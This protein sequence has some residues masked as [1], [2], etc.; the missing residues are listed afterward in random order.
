[1]QH[2]QQ[3]FLEALKAAL[4][5]EQIEWNNKV[6]AQEWMDLFR[7]AEVHQ[8]LP[9]IYEAVYRSPAAGQ[10]DPQILAP[11]KAQMV[12]T[13]IMQTQKTGEFEPLYRYL[14]ESGI[15]P[16]VVKG[17]VCRNIYPNP[18]YRISGD[19]DLLIRP[20]DF[21]KCHDLLREYGM[22]TSEQ[23]MDAEE[24]ESVYEVPY[25]KKGSLIYI[26]LHKSL[27]PPESEA[28]GDLNR[29]FANVHEDAIDIRIDG[30]DIRTMG[31][32]DHLFYLICHSFKHFLH[33]GFGIR[34]VCDIILFANEYGDAIDWEKIL[35]QCREI[36]ADLFAAALFAIGEKYLTF[37]PEKAHYPK[38]WQGICVDETDMLNEDSKSDEVPVR[39]VKGLAEIA[40][41]YYA[42]GNHELDY[43]GTAEG[44]KMQKHP[45]NSELVKDL[46]DA[47]ACVLEEGYRDVEI[48]GCKVRIGGMY[49]YAFALDGDNS[50]ENLTGDVRDFLEEF[51]NTD[52]YKIMLCH[53]PDSFVFG[54][55]SDYWKIDLVISG[56][57]H[58]GQ[59]VIPFKGG[60]YGG[61]QGWF[62]PYVHGLYR[63][64]RI[65]L[66]VTS[67]LSSEKQKLPRWNNR[68]EIAVLN[69]H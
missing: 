34:Q 3:L 30:T 65:R 36:H 69:V 18:D 26:E 62:P 17:I 14:R 11:A 61:D 46:T 7:M 47:G 2:T 5:N 29:F 23:D 24:L 52:R 13:V 54:D 51:Q 15:C 27:F 43:I 44:K 63:T 55:A 53:R 4:K 9:M 33:S 41:V 50:A 16:L 68:P 42:L 56:H 40:P 60:L 8:I 66:F 59:V 35:R 19:E 45:E 57:D 49:E 10:A 67:G 28:Y 39:L 20:E 31:Y 6:E 1:M 64:G 38:V 37:D 58:G 32:T 22:Q 12:R 25:G 21:R 48:G